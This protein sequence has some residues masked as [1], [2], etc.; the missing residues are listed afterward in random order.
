MAKQRSKGSGSKEA[1][2]NRVKDEEVE[3]APFMFDSERPEAGN[4]EKG[5]T[6]D[7]G[8]PNMPLG[9]FGDAEMEFEPFMFDQ[10]AV[11]Q[12]PANG[13]STDA[14]P[15]GFSFEPFSIPGGKPGANATEGRA[16]S[17]TR[18]EDADIIGDDVPL[19]FYLA[20]SQSESTESLEPS[21]WVNEDQPTTYTGG[22]ATTSGLVLPTGPI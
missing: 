11:E 14:T 19:P 1:R 8:L 18:T 15:A 10:G 16:P 4:K 5:T 17:N 13:A 6:S 3:V 12:L 20:D 2:A 22:D 7:S 9:Q 21:H